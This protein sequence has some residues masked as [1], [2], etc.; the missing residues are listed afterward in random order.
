MDNHKRDDYLIVVST[1]VAIL[2]S[3]VA[4]FILPLSSNYNFFDNSVDPYLGLL[5]NLI[6][7]ITLTLVFFLPIVKW[8]TSRAMSE[9]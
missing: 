4:D 8:I 6:I 5:T 3:K 9:D 7:L 2:S 1:V